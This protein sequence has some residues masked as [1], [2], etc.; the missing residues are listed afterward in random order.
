M[1]GIIAKYLR[2]L[3]IER[4]SSKHTLE[5]YRCD[6]LQFEQSLASLDGGCP[7]P[8]DLTRFHIR[9]FL[10]QLSEHDLKRASVQRKIA[11]LRSFFKY[12][13]QRG[14]TA[15]NLAVYLISPKSEKRLPKVLSRRELEITLNSL[16]DDEGY[17]EGHSDGD[18]DGHQG[19]HSV[20]DSE[21]DASE[22]GVADSD[23]R[24]N[25][26]RA[27]KYMSSAI[28]ELLYSTGI[29]VSELVQ[30]D[31]NDVDMKACQIKVL[32]KGA[33]QRI[34]PFGSAAGEALSAYLN[35]RNYLENNKIESG[36]VSALF[37]TIRG[38]RI[39]TRAVQRMVHSIL[40]QHSEAT[41][42]SPHA[43]R[44]SFATHLLDNGADIRVIKELLGH[45]SL[46]ATQIYT[47]ASAQKLK[48]T[49]ERAHPRAEIQ[50]P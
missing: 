25:I 45:S 44:H 46:A 13:F 12:C 41:Q 22:H 6:L 48:E 16:G 27:W 21:G 42:K 10:G 37:L 32:G 30:L 9:T 24:S 26:D 4:N 18:S 5:A 3:E 7:A 47:S 39:Y 36:H 8:Q 38:R 11:T 50:K 15:K 17:A 33:K 43:L 14:I 29:R 28:M 2:Y 49:Y 34:V 31:L 20:G 19:S 1:K 23:N 40:S 35:V